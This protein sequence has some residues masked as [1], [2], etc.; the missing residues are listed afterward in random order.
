MNEIVLAET[1]KQI[2]LTRYLTT[3][4]PSEMD[5]LVK[6][7]PD[8][9]VC[10]IE[11]EDDVK[12]LCNSG[13]FAMPYARVFPLIVSIA[14][15][16]KSDTDN[17]EILNAKTLLN[18]A[19]SDDIIPMLYESNKYEHKFKPI[20]ISGGKVIS[21]SAK[22]YVKIIEVEVTTNWKDAV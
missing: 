5:G 17:E 22:S 10:L 11:C 9:C 19:V 18:T 6:D 16:L 8:V 1:V 4:N 13:A 14:K 12:L 2:I 3:T 7:N 21:A 15:Y 20:K